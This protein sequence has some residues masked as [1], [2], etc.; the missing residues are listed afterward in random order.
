[1]T[2]RRCGLMHNSLMVHKPSLI[3]KPGWAVR[4]FNCFVNIWRGNER[5]KLLRVVRKIRS[6]PRVS[7]SQ[8]SESGLIETRLSSNRKHRGRLQSSIPL[9]NVL[10]PLFM[11]RCPLLL[12]FLIQQ[13]VDK[14]PHLLWALLLQCDKPLQTP[15]K[16]C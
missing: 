6:P 4:T 9:L 10:L 3:Q 1:M 13:P 7:C 14:Q 2:F 8:K 5:L 16:Q 12:V 11:P 15:N